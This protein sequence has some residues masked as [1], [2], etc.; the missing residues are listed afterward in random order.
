M[1]ELINA[2]INEFNKGCNKSDEIKI[3][4]KDNGN[5]V[6]YEN[7]Y[8]VD[9]LFN[10][11]HNNEFDYIIE[12]IYTLQFNLHN[13][14]LKTYKCSTSQIETYLGISLKKYS[15]IKYNTELYKVGDYIIIKGELYDGSI[16]MKFRNYLDFGLIVSK[17]GTLYKCGSSGKCPCDYKYFGNDQNMFKEIANKIIENI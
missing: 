14:Y 9:T 1:D 8:H 10:E 5:V 13:F 11:V 17:N 4:F 6:V 2:V 12:F 3:E 7:G 15:N 16:P